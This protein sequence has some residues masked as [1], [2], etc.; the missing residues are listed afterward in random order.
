MCPLSET[1][2][3][4]FYFEVAIMLR[5]ALFIIGTLKNVEVCHGLTKKEISMLEAVDKILIRKILSVHSKTP[6]EVLYLELG[7]LPIC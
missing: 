7:C 4:E 1:S 3:Y 5:E 6:V 2:L